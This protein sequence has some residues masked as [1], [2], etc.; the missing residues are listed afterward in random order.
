MY[1]A[2]VT[3]ASRGIGR[4][5]ACALSDIGCRVIIN[6]NKSEKEAH[7]LEKSLPC[8]VA[9]KADISDSKQV[10]DMVC[11]AYKEYGSIDI[12]VNNAGISQQKLFFDV[13]EEDFDLMYSVNL[14]GMFNTCKAILPKMV[15]N[16]YG[17]IVNISSMWGITGGSCE[18]AY[19]AMKAGVIGFTKALAK[20]VGPSQVNVNCVAPGVIKTDMTANLSDEDLNLLIDETPIMRLGTPQDIA[21]AVAFLVSDSASFI[22]GQVLSSNGGIII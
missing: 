9:M 6:Y 21:N 8:A 10:I 13:T 16:R 12:L 22:T 20:E 2:L 11:L 19:S 7:E 14:K 15:Q 18:V 5:I 3:G 1:T 4:A 17:K